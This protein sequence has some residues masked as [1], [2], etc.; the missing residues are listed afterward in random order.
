[1]L[2]LDD[3]RWE[4]LTDGRRARNDLRPLLRRLESAD[5]PTNTWEELW[6]ALYHQGDI[7]DSAFAVVPHLVRIHAKRGVVEWNTYALAAMIEL[8]RG[9]GKN[10]DTPVWAG[11]AYAEA[12]RTLTSLG[13]AELPRAENPEAVRSILAILAIVHGARTYGGLLVQFSEDEVRE[14]EAVVLGDPSRSDAG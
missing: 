4:N 2:G 7:G 12:L 11:G 8:A 14:L 13:L 1:M 10:P 9:Q 6:D 3:A 5:D